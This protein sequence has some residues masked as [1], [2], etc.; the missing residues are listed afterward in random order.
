MMRDREGRPVQHNPDHRHTW[1]VSAIAG[2]DALE[3]CACGAGREVKADFGGQKIGKQGLVPSSAVT[4][5]HAPYPRRR[6][7]YR[8]R[9]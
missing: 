4:G 1:V 6:R 8:G 7:R 2:P 5:G 3:E 9:R